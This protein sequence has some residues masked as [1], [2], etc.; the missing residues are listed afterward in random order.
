MML[1]AAAGPLANLAM[2]VLGAGI[3]RFILSLD[4][5][6][7]GFGAGLAEAILKPIALMARSAVIVNVVLVVFNICPFFRSM[8]EES[9]LVCCRRVRP[10]RCAASSRMD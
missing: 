2:A 9:W 4:L 5:P 1:V 10:R 6:N 7:T 3:L 8:E